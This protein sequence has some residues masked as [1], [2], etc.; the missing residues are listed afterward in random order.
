LSSSLTCNVTA[1]PVTVMLTSVLVDQPAEDLVTSY[2]RR[3]Q[4]G[5]RG[6]EDAVAVRWPQVPGPVAMLV[7]VG[8]VLVQDRPMPLLVWRKTV[9][10][11]VAVVQS[12][13]SACILGW[14]CPIMSGWGR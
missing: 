10:G 2:P 5:D 6:C 4:V 12:L 11:D 8:D 1:G 7:I 9:H 14:A 13:E 3:R